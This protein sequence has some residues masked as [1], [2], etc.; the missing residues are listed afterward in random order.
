MGQCMF[1]INDV[2]WNAQPWPSG[3]SVQHSLECD[4]CVIG[5]GASGLTALTH[6]HTAGL[7]VIGIDAGMVGVGAAGSNGGFILAGIAAFHHDAVDVLGQERATRLYQR[8]LEEIQRL[9]QEEPTFEQRGSLRLAKDD[10]EYRDCQR[11]Y[12]I[13][14]R[15]GLAVEQ[16][17]GPEGRGILVP[18]DGVFQPLQRVRRMAH[19]LR[20]AGVPLY[21][22]SRVQHIEPTLVIANN[23]RIVCSHSIVAVDGNIEVL[24]PQLAGTL[25]TTRLQMMA[26]AP[27]HTVHL[28]R[29]VYYNYGYDYWQQRNDGTIAIGGARDQHESAEWGHGGYPTTAV[30]SSIE[31]RLRNT[32]GSTAPIRHR[33]GASVAYRLDDI[34]PFIGQVMPTV[35]ACGGYSGT[36]NI[37]GT[38][39]ARDIATAIVTGNQHPISRWHE[40][41]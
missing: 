12:T 28:P 19:T 11:Q 39:C 40:D 5:L 14:R 30:Q 31:A 27:D 18:T 10:E 33:W 37:V 22:R 36:G 41:R 34:R 6:L 16:Y 8:T 2:Y 26:T 7:R 24:L 25:R 1:S 35:W 9:S 29:P 3:P 20:S 23:H 32:V 17:D 15:D 4:V 13:M 21:E 38:L